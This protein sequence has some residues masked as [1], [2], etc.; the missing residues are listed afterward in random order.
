MPCAGP[1]HSCNSIL[2]IRSPLGELRI[3]APESE[4]PSPRTLW[5]LARGLIW[6][7]EAL[8]HRRQRRALAKLDDRLLDDTGIS[9]SEADREAGRQPWQ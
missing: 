7:R 5:W 4:R 1:D 2:F 8:A 9:R 6:V 3:G